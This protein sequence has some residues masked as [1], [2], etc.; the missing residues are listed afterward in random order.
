MLRTNVV[1]T[2]IMLGLSAWLV[3]SVAPR[4]QQ[5]PALQLEASVSLGDVR[6][7]IDHM[8]IDLARQRLLVAELGNDSLGVVDLKERKVV[9]RISGLSEPQGIGYVPSTDTLY[10]ANGGDGSLR[11][12]TGAQYADGVRLSLGSDA[13][14]VR[15][16]SAGNRV[17]VG[18]GRG[19][20][21]VIDAAT[22]GRV[23]DVR[24]KGHPESFQLTRDGDRAFV[25]IPNAHEIAV[26]DL[27][28]GRQIGSWPMRIAAANF[29]LALDEELQRVL[30]VFRSPAKLGVFSMQ[31]G[32]LVASPDTCGDADD[33]FFDAKRHRA[34]VSCGGGAID[35]I[36]AQ[37]GAYRSIARA[38]TA[39]GARTSLFPP[40]LDRLFVAARAQ[41]GEPASI[42][43]FRPLP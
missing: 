33:I 16:N 19:A 18:Y 9:H 17:V 23:A 27:R 22:G 8:A 26:V 38:P 3:Q 4:A 1:T 6:G 34:Y 10:V 36:D 13:D 37:D 11:R 40:E 20:L 12:F 35:V 15:V 28:A 32:N 43:V 7:R 24:L 39:A 2:S 29:P 31:D 41:R 5:P 25:N 14:N 42:R 21:A 30:T